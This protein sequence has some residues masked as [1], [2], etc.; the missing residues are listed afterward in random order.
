M[1]ATN[2]G[3][4]GRVEATVNQEMVELNM[5]VERLSLIKTPEE[6]QRALRH[7]RGRDEILKLLL[8]EESLLKDRNKHSTYHIYPNAKWSLSLVL[9]YS[10]R[11]FSFCNRFNTQVDFVAILEQAYNDDSSAVCTFCNA[12]LPK[13]RM[14]VHLDHWCSAKPTKALEEDAMEE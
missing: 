9:T 12:L 1:K 2:E 4:K 10:N 6:V 11:F 8:Q 3:G 7:S 13:T 14:Q 5:L